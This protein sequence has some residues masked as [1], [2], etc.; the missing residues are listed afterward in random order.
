MLHPTRLDP[1]STTR[2][3]H[4]RPPEGAG[5]P[6]PA[7]G[8]R[9]PRRVLRLGGRWLRA[10]GAALLRAEKHITENFRVPPHGG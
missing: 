7:A 4:A 3:H 5:P 6:S 2:Q 9:W 1:E 8:S 10:L